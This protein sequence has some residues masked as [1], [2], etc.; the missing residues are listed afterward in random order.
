[1][2]AGSDHS[3]TGTP[4]LCASRS[5]EC[6]CRLVELGEDLLTAVAGPRVHDQVVPN[7]TFVEHWSAGAASFVVSQQD[8]QVRHAWAAL[9]QDLA[10]SLR[11]L[12]LRTAAG[13]VT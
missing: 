13:Y 10:A 4:F 12:P 9:V 2:L 6:A 3:P 1:M 8:I 5:T 11:P 7:A